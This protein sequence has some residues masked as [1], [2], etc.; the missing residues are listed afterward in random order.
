MELLYV[1]IPV[2][3]LVAAGFLLAFIWAA[4]DDQFSDLDTPATRMLHEPPPVRDAE[5]GPPPEPA[6]PESGE[7]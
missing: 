5:A 1:A 3:L 2:S 6:P 4:R 7:R